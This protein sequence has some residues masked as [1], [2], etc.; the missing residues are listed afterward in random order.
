LSRLLFLPLAAVTMS[1]TAPVAAAPA[2]A[3]NPL[4]VEWSQTNDLP[5][6]DLIR[7]E[8]YEPA[9][10]EGIRQAQTALDAI[11]GNSAPP[12]F[13]NTIEALERAEPLLDRVSATFFTV[14][15]ADSRPDIQQIEARITPE[16]SRFSSSMLLDPKLFA[17]VDAVWK[18]RDQL[19]LSPEQARLL[20]ITHRRFVRAGAALPEAQRNRLA[21]IDTEVSQLQVEFSQNLLAD[22]KAADAFLTKAEM[23]GLPP[24]TITAAA[25]KAVAAGKAGMY[26][27]SS[28]RSDVENFLTLAD[29]RNA[30][31][32]IF[33]AFNQRGDNGDARDNNALITRM[34]R[35][36]LEKAK[37]LGYANHADYVLE[38]SMAKTPAAANELLTRVYT[39]ARNRAIR[40]EADLLVL[41][42]A[43]GLTK[44]EPWD[45]RYYSEKL[46]RDRYAFDANQLQQYL[47]LDGMVDALFESARRLFGLTFAPRADA[48]VYADGVRVWEVKKAD[49]QQLGLFYADWFARDTKRPGAWMNALRPQNGLTGAKPIVVNNANFTPPAPGE[50]ATLTFDDAE[51]LFHEFGHALHGLFS[52]TRYPSLAGTA[53][54][55]DFVEFPSQINEHWV[56]EPDILS[57]YAR[58]A[59]GDPLP[60]ELLTNLL[61]ARTFNQGYLTVQQLASALVDM[62]LH[63]QAEFPEDFSPR[64]FEQ[65]TLLELQVPEAVGMRHRL[66]HFSHLFDGGYHAGYYAYT[67]AEVLE[68]DAFDAFTEAGSAWDQPTATRYRAEILERGNS[69]DPAESWLA[70]RGREPLPDALL[71]NR[72]L[73]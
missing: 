38:D 10:A 37:L 65:Q 48:P 46:R 73:E 60:P 12:D 71:R 17:R 7:P 45:W 72:G 43:D 13:A 6:Y 40:E 1:V 20:E 19:N 70:F 68:A 69:R 31:R 11:S 18:Q 41:A 39:A 51:T 36:R 52:R 9:F 56:S 32:K 50:R 35:L 26:L 59:D 14:A 49:G 24:A 21:A 42:K 8:H 5:P 25:T 29:D 22:Q 53:V 15:G 33:T 16:L 30:R 63:Q 2:I 57:K 54:Y 62:K 28:S 61:K 64:V 3:A 47:P 55:R 58:N 44:I 67:W 23:S 27:I 34:L 66:A 4:L